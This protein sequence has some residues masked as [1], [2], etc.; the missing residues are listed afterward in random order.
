MKDVYKQILLKALSEGIMV[1]GV[2]AGKEESFCRLLSENIENN[3][4]YFHY[5]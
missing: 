1:V 4:E 2:K 5:I 3:G